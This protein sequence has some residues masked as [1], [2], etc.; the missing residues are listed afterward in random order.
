M[1][2]WAT[3]HDRRRRTRPVLARSVLV[4]RARYSVPRREDGYLKASSTSI[5]S[6]CLD[7]LLQSAEKRRIVGGY[8]NDPWCHG[9]CPFGALRPQHVPGVTVDGQC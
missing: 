4:I 6:Q 5:R 3:S 8:V 1:A 7:D 2:V 9:L